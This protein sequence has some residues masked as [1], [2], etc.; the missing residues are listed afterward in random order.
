MKFTLSLPAILCVMFTS[1]CGMSSSTRTAAEESGGGG[2]SPVRVD[3]RYMID[4][5]G[6]RVWLVGFQVPWTFRREGRTAEDHRKF[7]RQLGKNASE[8]YETGLEQW[9]TEEDAKRIKDLGANSIRL[10]TVYWTFETEP[11]S[12]SEEAFQ[13]VDRVIEDCGKHGVYVILSC[14]SAPGGQ[15][16]AGHGGAGGKNEFWNEP[17]YQ[18]RYVDLWKKIAERYRMSEAVAGYDI[19]NEPVP[20]SDAALSVVYRNIVEA[21]RS[22]GDR[23]VIFLQWPLKAQS[24]VP[25]ISDDNVAY[26]FHFYAPTEFTH[27]RKPGTR[28]PGNIAGRNFNR[29]NLERLIERRF[30]DKGQREGLCLWVG[31]FGAVASAPEDDELEWIGDCIRIWEKHNIGWCYYL[32]KVP[33]SDRSFALYTAPK[34]MDEIL[35]VSDIAAGKLSEEKFESLRTEKFVVNQGLYDL[36]A[37]HLK[38]R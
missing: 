29:E 32:Y 22:T 34:D 23:H 10:V 14:N 7:E 11:Y 31:E 4:S 26:S 9:F 19:L 28:Y 2:V 5:K 16:P 30:L 37:D 6:Q 20:P 27:Q 36:L 35:P 33:K 24:A 38:D 1:V 25:R 13:R 3:G 8:Y 21:I 15:N 18:K 17:E 12:Y